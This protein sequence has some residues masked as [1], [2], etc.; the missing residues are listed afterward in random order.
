MKSKARAQFIKYFQENFEDRE[1][2]RTLYTRDVAKVPK[3]AKKLIVGFP[4]GVILVESAADIQKAYNI[5]NKFK[6][7]IIPRAGATTGFGGSLV[8][9]NGIILDLT[10]LNKIIDIE[11]A[12]QSVTVEPGVTFE[13]LERML[14]MQSLAL[15]SYPSSFYSGTV[16]GWIANGGDGIGSLKYGNVIDQ[17]IG[18]EVVLPDGTV[19]FYTEKDD[20]RMFVGAQGTTGVITKIKLRFRFDSPLVHLGCT[21]DNY[22]DLLKGLSRFRELEPFSVWF[23]NKNQVEALNKS[24]GFI[25]PSRHLV[26]VSKEINYDEEREEY[27]EKFYKITR[28]EQGQILADYYIRDIW[29]ARY[30]TFSLLKDLNDYVLGEVVLPLDYTGKYLKALMKK[31]SKHICIEGTMTSLACCSLFLT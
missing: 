14:N 13:A 27:R 26:I 7:P 18:L 17:L 23:L 24:L 31:L 10:K 15:C 12:D 8:Y 20:F 30:R 3:P 25:I 6:V 22:D 5:A 21:F 28:E 2:I 16:G 9:K 29:K 19:K 11:L 1:H 4:D